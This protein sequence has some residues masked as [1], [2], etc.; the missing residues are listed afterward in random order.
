MRAV[1]DKDKKDWINQKKTV[2]LK[3]VNFLKTTVDK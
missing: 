3:R 2:K 1:V